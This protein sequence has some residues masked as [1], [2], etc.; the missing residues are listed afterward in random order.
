L[1][2]KNQSVIHERSVSANPCY[3]YNSSSIFN[4]ILGTDNSYHN[5]YLFCRKTKSKFLLFWRSILMTMIAPETKS[6]ELLVCWN[7]AQPRRSVTI[8]F[9]WARTI[10]LFIKWQVKLARTLKTSPCKWWIFKRLINELYSEANIISE[11]QLVWTEIPK[12]R[13]PS[14][15]KFWRINTSILDFQMRS[16]LSISRWPL[17]PEVIHNLESIDL[18]TM[19]KTQRLHQLSIRLMTRMTQSTTARKRVWANYVVDSWAF[20]ANSRRI[21]FCSTSAREN[22]VWRGEGSTIS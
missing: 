17:S 14:R 9:A 21:S 11:V 10:L 22:W 12:S 16:T 7:A 1:L 5:I 4:W 20:M 8:C 15:M 13:R 18:N 3:I 2:T 6:T 19:R